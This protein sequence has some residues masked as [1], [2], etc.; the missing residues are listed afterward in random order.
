MKK[1]VPALGQHAAPD[2]LGIPEAA[3]VVLDE[4]AL[5]ITVGGNRRLAAELAEIFLQELVSRMPEMA[6]AVVARDNTRIQFLAHTLMGSAASLSATQVTGTARKLE[7]MA[8]TG[9]L[10]KVDAV[11]AR[12]EDEIAKLSARLTTFIRES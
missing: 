9:K 6:K 7:S 1:S 5:L 8:L 4:K 10:A 12:L 11:F 3:G 2:V